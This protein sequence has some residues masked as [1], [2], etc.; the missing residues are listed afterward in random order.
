MYLAIAVPS[1]VLRRDRTGRGCHIDLAMY[2]AVLT[3]FAGFGVHL[4]NFGQESQ[5]GNN[6]LWG[7]FNTANRPLV[8]TAHRTSQYERFCRALDRLEWLTDPR[9]GTPAARADNLEEL[10]MLTDEVLKT[11]DAE[12]WMERFE[13][14]GVSYA[15]TLTVEEALA[16]AHTQAREMVVEVTS[17]RGETMKLIGNPI[18][19]DDV[20]PRYTAPPQPGEHTVDV[21]GEW[22]SLDTAQVAALAAAGAVYAQPA[23]VSEVRSAS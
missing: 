14:A 4:L 3:W 23:A 21:L 15:E 16:H 13:A 11:R 18:K 20:T 9:F 12:E 22:L 6:V 5:I 17:R 8:I 2:D 1:A 19:V 7:S 10:K